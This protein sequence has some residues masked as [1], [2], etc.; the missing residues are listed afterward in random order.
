[1]KTGLIIASSPLTFTPQKGGIN[2]FPSD[3]EDFI[4]RDLTESSGPINLFDSTSYSDFKLMMKENI[5]EQE[6]KRNEEMRTMEEETVVGGIWTTNMIRD[7]EKF[8]FD[9]PSEEIRKACE[10]IFV[11]DDGER[12]ELPALNWISDEIPDPRGHLDQMSG[13]EH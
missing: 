8:E 9:W 2:L 11:T 5:E 3:D 6:R 13:I 1:M 4:S 7:D 10:E 12:E